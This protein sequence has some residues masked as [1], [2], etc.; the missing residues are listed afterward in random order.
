MT[1][2]IYTEDNAN[3]GFQMIELKGILPNGFFETMIFM[4]KIVKY[5]PP[6]PIKT[7]KSTNAIIKPTSSET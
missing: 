3:A 2:T 1:L 6:A 7:P 4:I 5:T